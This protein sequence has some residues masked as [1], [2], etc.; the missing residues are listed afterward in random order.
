M[1]VPTGVRAGFWYPGPHLYC[2]P[3][4]KWKEAFR[5][6]AT[7]NGPDLG[8]PVIGTRF[9]Q[10]LMDGT[11]EFSVGVLF[12]P[13]RGKYQKLETILILHNYFEEM[14]DYSDWEKCDL[15]ATSV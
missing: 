2:P 11:L 7:Y 15:S 5:P 13:D 14:F 8:D 4:E 6:I 1:R 10:K 3:M 12:R 9:Q